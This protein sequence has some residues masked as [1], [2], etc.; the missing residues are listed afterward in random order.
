MAKVHSMT[1]V[2]TVVF[3]VATLTAM[4]GCS[5]PSAQPTPAAQPKQTATAPSGAGTPAAKPASGT[6]YKIGGNF[7]LTATGGTPIGQDYKAGIDAFVEILNA[8]GGINGRPLQVISYDNENSQEKALQLAKR[9]IQED[10]VLAMVVDRT[11]HALALGPT[12][13]EAGVVMINAT[14]N[15]EATQGKK[16]VFQNVPRDEIEADV[17]FTHVKN[18]LKVDKVAILHDENQY[19]TTGAGIAEKKASEKGIKVTAK[20][21]YNNNSPDLTTEVTRARA[22]GAD[23]IVTWGIPPGPANIAKAARNMGWNAPLIGSV[24][25]A[26]P[27]IIQL[28]GQAVEGMTFEAWF[29]TENPDEDDK[30]FVETYKKKTGKS[31]SIFAAL[32]WDAG[33]L[34]AEGIKIGSD[35]RG[36]IRDALEQLKG[37]KGVVGTYNM[38]PSD[39]NGIAPDSILLTQIKG[40]KWTVFKQTR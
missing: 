32:G 27:V 1:W 34:L 20:I 26:S 7:V 29:D 40:G 37:F 35:D 30:L 19:G 16:W 24:A 38:S 12:V 36:K 6:P 4:L 3:L 15:Y 11:A 23:A 14:A 28:A 18:N 5:Q 21:P 2:L 8:S 39:H 9:M 10:K 31:P 33:A 25:S 17:L 13:E 22:S